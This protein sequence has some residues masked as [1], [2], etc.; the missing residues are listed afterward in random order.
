MGA[1][2]AT[3]DASQPA[4]TSAPLDAADADR[5]DEGGDEGTEVEPTETAPAIESLERRPAELP[6]AAEPVERV[7]ESGA[8]SQPPSTPSE[9]PAADSTHEPPA[10]SD[11]DAQ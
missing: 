8:V 6:P 2:G 9:A 11:P 5:D 10:G 1:P 7:A 3:P 4:D